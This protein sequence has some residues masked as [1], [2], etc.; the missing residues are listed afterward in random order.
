MNLKDIN[1]KELLNLFVGPTIWKI[2]YIKLSD[3]SDCNSRALPSEVTYEVEDGKIFFL[4]VGPLGTIF[5]KV[6]TDKPTE[7]TGEFS[8]GLVIYL[9]KTN[10]NFKIMKIIKNFK[11]KRN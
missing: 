2:D 11:I 6:N 1:R 4:V 7:G 9:K 8:M 5:F 3:K 10:K